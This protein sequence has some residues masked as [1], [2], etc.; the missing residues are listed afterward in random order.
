MGRGVSGVWSF[1]DVKFWGHLVLGASRVSSFGGVKFG[2]RQ[3]SGASNFG[4]VEVLG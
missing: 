1:E 4:G 3:T 2:G